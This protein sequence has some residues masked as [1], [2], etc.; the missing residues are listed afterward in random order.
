MNPIIADA[1]VAQHRQ[2]LLNTAE[3]YRRV[4]RTRNA[5]RIARIASAAPVRT[6]HVRPMFQTWLAAGRL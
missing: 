3:H 2:D 4:R 6:S 1:I 5:P